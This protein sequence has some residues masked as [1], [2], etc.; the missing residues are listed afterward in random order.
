[1]GPKILQDNLY[2]LSALGRYNTERR[3]VIRQYFDQELGHNRLY[4]EK[5]DLDDVLDFSEN[6]QSLVKEEA[7]FT[8]I[9]EQSLL[10]LPEDINPQDFQGYL[11]LRFAHLE[12][13]LEG[14]RH[15]G[16]YDL[17]S[18]EAL[19]LD[20]ILEVVE[21]PLQATAQF[22]S[23]EDYAD[24]SA[25]KEPSEAFRQRWSETITLPVKTVIQEFVDGTLP[26]DPLYDPEL[27]KERINVAWD[28]LEFLS[29]DPE[30]TGPLDFLLNPLFRFG[31]RNSKLLVPFPEVLVT[32]A[33]Y[34][35]EAYIDQ[36]NEIQAVENHKKGDTV[37]Q[38]AHDLLKQI[39]SRN[40]VKQFHYIHDEKPGEAD[41][42]LFFDE[43]T[44]VVEVKSHP[45]FRK[46][47]RNL[48][49]IKH[50]FADIV[51][52]A[53]G[54][55]RKT[56]D[57]LLDQND[58]FGLLY[59]LTGNR[60]HDQNSY[61]GIVILDGFIP[62]LFSGNEFADRQVGV[63]EL[64]DDIDKDERFVVITL[65]DLYQL[66]QQPEVESFNQ[67]LKWR[68]GYEGNIPVWGYSEREYWAFFFDL[69]KDEEEFQEAMREAV[70]KKIV[71]I[72]ISARFNDKPHLPDF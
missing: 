47:P 51:G 34:R 49:I 70:R 31:T 59:H 32:T 41:G 7:E 45:I 46:I 36:F 18:M 58:D 1:M 12:D 9:F 40:F 42:I 19:L 13:A 27:N 66:I 44:W 35:I 26:D 24:L 38:L 11:L 28:I 25:I 69:F 30:S 16:V 2:Y 62:T 22:E 6:K 61:G 21:N 20:S 68:T 71:T 65:Y 72:Y 3:P 64:H 63:G 52:R 10:V 37:E 17:L 56:L 48:D 50:R 67:F 23:K 55:T 57:Y 60:N 4:N 43:S 33:Q 54:Q 8:E 5:V 14:R 15:F 53:H 39:P 29:T